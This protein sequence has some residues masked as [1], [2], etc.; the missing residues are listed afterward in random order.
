MIGKSSAVPT[1]RRACGRATAASRTIRWRSNARPRTSSCS[2]SCTRDLLLELLKP[3]ELGVG[4]AEREQLVVGAD[5]H[6]A[7]LGEHH[8]AVGG[9]RGAQAMRHE[10]HRQPGRGRAQR[11]RDL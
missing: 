4:A 5:L 10:E 2:T 7:A 11:R 3:P 1:I 9:A 6:Y 8:D